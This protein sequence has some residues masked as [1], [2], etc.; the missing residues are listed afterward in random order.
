MLLFKLKSQATKIV[1]YKNSSIY[2]Y[3]SSLDFDRLKITA[4]FKYANDLCIKQFQ[5][6]MILKL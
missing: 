3:F 5:L 6:C 4:Y 2:N 1:I